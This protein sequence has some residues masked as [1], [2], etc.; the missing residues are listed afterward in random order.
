MKYAQEIL[1]KSWK[2]QGRRLGNKR[3]VQVVTSA[4]CLG[5]GW[6]PKYDNT[7]PCPVWCSAGEIKASP[8]SEK[9][10]LF[11]AVSA[12]DKE[13]YKTEVVRRMKW[14]LTVFPVDIR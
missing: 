10:G 3:F 2:L 6:D 1:A 13:S 14:R 12:R 7:S 8:P 5:S 11:I 9:R 4:Y